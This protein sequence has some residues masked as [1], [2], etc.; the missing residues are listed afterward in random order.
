M[1]QGAETS[2]VGGK[3]K[4]VGS[5]DALV[6]FFPITNLWLITPLPTRASALLRYY[7]GAT[8]GSTAGVTGGTTGSGFA[9]KSFHSC[10][11]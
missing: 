5:A 11:V 1:E 2:D 9:S 8:G 7:C 6:G 3:L 10:N 4:P